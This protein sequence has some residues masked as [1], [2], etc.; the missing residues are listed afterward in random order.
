VPYVDGGDA[1]TGAGSA[2]GLDL[3]S[4]APVEEIAAA[5]GF[6]TPVTYRH[7]FGRLMR[8]SPSAYRRAFRTS[9]AP[10]VPAGLSHGGVVPRL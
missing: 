6:G 8:T 9:E 5:V 10:P 4:R 2:A 7:H 3:T 1:L